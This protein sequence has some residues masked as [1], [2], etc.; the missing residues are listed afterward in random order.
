MKENLYFKL[1][2]LYKNTTYTKAQ[3]HYKLY[4]I[5]IKVYLRILINAQAFLLMEVGFVLTS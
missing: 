5:F 3:E 4:I 1:L 2:I